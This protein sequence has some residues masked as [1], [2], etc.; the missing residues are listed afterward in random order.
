MD[1]LL[2]ALKPY[3]LIA[4]LDGKVSPLG[5]VSYK[6]EEDVRNGAK[7]FDA[8]GNPYTPI[9][10]K[11]VSPEASK[12]LEIIKP[13]IGNALGQMGHNMV[14][15]VFPRKD[16]DGKP[17]VVPTD[18]GRFKIELGGE[19]F[20]YRL[21]LAALSPRLKCK[22]DPELFPSTYKYCPYDGTPLVPQTPELSG[23]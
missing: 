17:I 11:D 2:K 14:F 9:D 21:P 1:A 7:I 5:A 16:Q 4:V 15:M 19:D 22:N 18:T 23:K 10:A 13:I 8:T 3:I 12:V 20:T 6:T